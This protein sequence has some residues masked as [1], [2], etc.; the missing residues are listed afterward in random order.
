MTGM[1]E[2]DGGA[3]TAY[4]SDPEGPVRG[5]VIVI[6]EIWGLV[7]H[8]KDIA[9]RF[10]AE[11]YIAIAPDLL[12]GVGIPPE[13]GLQLIPLMFETDDA[14]K[15]AAQPILRDKLAPLHA[16]EFG[17]WA[18]NA[19]TT[20]VD[21]LADQPEVDGNIAVVGYCFGGTYSFA[22]AAADPRVRAAVP[23][24]GQPPE[25]TEVAAIGCPVLALYGQHDPSLM[26]NLPAVT[27]AM[28]D[29]GVDFRPH[30]YP[31][32][33]HA[34]FN[35]TNPVTYRADDASDAWERTLAFLGET[36]DTPAGVV[37]P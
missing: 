31:D 15:S 12:T 28:A 22:L 30:V 3:F 14:K 23:F 1:I 29:A 32:S 26:S 34:F 37:T 4:R 35:N 8:I 17:E 19:L 27:A 25:A 33:G 2:L 10:A 13:V 16:P 11:G 7:D 18:V 36:L 9:D 24:Y 20:V 5:A 6:H 21:Y